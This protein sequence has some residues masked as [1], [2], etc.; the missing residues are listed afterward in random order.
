MNTT[1][2]LGVV[3][4]LVVCVFALVLARLL[5][6]AKLPHERRRDDDEQRAW[7]NQQALRRV[8]PAI[9]LREPGPASGERP[10][11]PSQLSSQPPSQPSG[12]SDAPMDLTRAEPGAEVAERPD[13]DG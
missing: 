6:A 12:A 8:E 5:R 4:A 10:P 9:D 2:W 11:P 3:L 1:G 7:L 13:A